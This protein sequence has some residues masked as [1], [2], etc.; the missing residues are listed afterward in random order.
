VPAH[1][2]PSQQSLLALSWLNFFLSGMQTAFGP[3][4]AAYLVV[5]GW[6]AED[7]GFTLSIG[8]TASLVSQVPGGELVDSVRAKRLLV[9][10][11][12]VAVALSVLILWLWSSFP[13]VALAE[14]LQGITGGVLG[15]AVV[16]IS[17]ALVGHAG[18][19]ERLGHNQRFA[20]A[21]GVAVTVTMAFIAYSGSRWAMFLPVVLAVPVL[22]ALTQIRAEEINFGRACG[23][24]LANA[25]VPER[26]S[27]TALLKMKPSSVRTFAI[28]LCVLAWESLANTDPTRSSVETGV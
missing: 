19:S 14:V 15:P 21:G 8:G 2:A 1:A 26:A 13:L 17:L 18:L 22:V 6:R 16:A 10:A 24:E 7:I 25:D 9:A 5:Q 28:R 20:A 12:V 27:R 3:I 4:V 11:G 23:A